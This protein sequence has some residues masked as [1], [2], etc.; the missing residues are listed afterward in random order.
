[1]RGPRPLLPT[2]MDQ[3]IASRR[4]IDVLMERFYARAMTD[5]VIG[6]FFTEVARLDLAHHLPVIGDFWE[7]TLFGTGVYAKHRRNPLL[8]HTALSAKET[9]EPEHFRRWI[10]LFDDSIDESFAGMRADFLKSRGRA[11]ARRM[12]EFIG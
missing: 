10:E 6:H 5:P 7:S 11:I 3:D 1:M 12:L 9:L 8:V 2:A 4:D